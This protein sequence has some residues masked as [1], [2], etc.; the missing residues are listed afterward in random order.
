MHA[1]FLAKDS[2][3]F[4]FIDIEN[5]RYHPVIWNGFIENSHRGQPNSEN[6]SYPATRGVRYNIIAKARRRETSLDEK[7]IYNI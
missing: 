2:T 3:H 4:V 1:C 5:I 6:N 7:V